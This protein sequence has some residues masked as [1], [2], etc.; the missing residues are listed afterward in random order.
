MLNKSNNNNLTIIAKLEPKCYEMH[1][2]SNCFVSVIIINALSIIIIIIMPKFENRRWEK[3]TFS[4]TSKIVFLDKKI[5][6]L[7][8]PN[9]K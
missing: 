8:S 9:Q 5:S 1:L 2:F 6:R 3:T 7:K 4:A